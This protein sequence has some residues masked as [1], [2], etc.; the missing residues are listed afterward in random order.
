MVFLRTQKDAP[1]SE[2]GPSLDVLGSAKS[3]GGRFED[4]HRRLINLEQVVYGHTHAKEY[5]KQE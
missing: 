2:K 5:G 4:L 3:S 1:R